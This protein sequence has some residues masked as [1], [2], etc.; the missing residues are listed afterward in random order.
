MDTPKIPVGRT[1]DGRQFFLTTPFVPAKAGAAGAEFV[2]L[3]RFDA[4]GQLIEGAIDNL[5]PRATLDNDARRHVYERC[6]ARSIPQRR[7]A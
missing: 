6:T 4:A 3:Y 1:A 7:L 5:G 2:A